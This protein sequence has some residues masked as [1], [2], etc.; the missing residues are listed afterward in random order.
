MYNLKRDMTA[1]E[2]CAVVAECQSVIHCNPTCEEMPLLLVPK[3]KISR[4]PMTSS[5]AVHSAQ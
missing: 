5:L 2:V 4:P 1:F 3:D